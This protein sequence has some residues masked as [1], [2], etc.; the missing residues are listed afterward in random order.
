MAINQPT[1][2][3]RSTFCLF[4]IFQNKWSAYTKQGRAYTP[5]PPPGAPGAARPAPMGRAAQICEVQ[6]ASAPQNCLP[7]AWGA[8]ILHSS[9]G[10]MD[11]SVA[12]LA[13]DL[14]SGF[15]G[16]RCCDKSF[17]EANL[18]EGCDRDRATTGAA[19]GQLTS[20]VWNHE[21]HELG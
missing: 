10:V 2:Y 11:L 18:T 5:P 6:T 19:V 16:Q 13:H 3:K 4:E 17:K 20:A 15:Y 21:K 1:L 14:R 9:S 12:Y 8:R 7:S